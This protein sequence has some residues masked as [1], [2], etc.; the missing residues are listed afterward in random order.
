MTKER[1]TPKRPKPQAADP[2]LHYFQPGQVVLQVE[3]AGRLTLSHAAS[4]L[5]R[6]DPALK[7]VELRLRRDTR[8]PSLTFP[9]REGTNFSWLMVD[10]DGSAG[11][12]DRLLETLLQLDD[13]I[14]D[15]LQSG[16]LRLRAAAPNWLA[17]G[18]PAQ[19]GTGGPGGRPTKAAPAG[20]NG[21][22]AGHL[23]ARGAAQPEGDG[24]GV[25][26]I[27]L[28]TAPA[29]H[30]LVSTYFEWST[31]HPGQHPLLESLLR[32]G[33]PLHVY[34]AVA[35]DLHRLAAYSLQDG[36][37]LMTDHGLFAA[38]IIHTLAPSAR[39]HLV[40]VLNPYGVGDLESIAAGLQ[41]M[42]AAR[43]KN[44]LV[45]NCS[46]VLNAPLAGHGDPGPLERIRTR[47][48][49][50]LSRWAMPIEAL[51]QWVDRQGVAMVAAAGNDAKRNHQRGHSGRPS[52]RYPA[53]ADTVIGVGAL[54]RGASGNGVAAASYSNLA[55]R[56]QKAGFVTLGGEDGAENGVL[57]LYIGT[58]PDGRPNDTKWAWWAGTSFA[59]PIVTGLVAGLLGNGLSGRSADVMAA[60]AGL[61]AN[62][63]AQ[64]EMVLDISQA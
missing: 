63:T 54:P 40:E 53:A 7:E 17:G 30:D 57:G 19:I 21:R 36:R 38:G 50:Q 2:Q 34:P 60:L 28:D 47:H 42:L 64:Q 13:L 9:G 27:I 8:R 51:C 11:R 49:Q 59:T 10:V 35:D 39:L 58:F 1:P 52:A 24:R 18:A 25:D 20:L 23:G 37:Y 14:G 15:G 22:F 32:P 16:G 29:L 6:L 45:I 55:D 31:T 48:P 46:L 41:Q 12:P 56:P 26:V 43:R 61:A 44:P 5:K 33:G 4:L 62:R 3:H